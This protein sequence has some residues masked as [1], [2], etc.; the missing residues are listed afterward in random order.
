[1]KRH[2]VACLL[3][4]LAAVGVGCETVPVTGRSHLVLLSGGEETKLG[5]EAY[6]QILAKSKLSTDP[7]ANALVQRVGSRIAAVTGQSYPWEYRVIEDRQARP[8][9]FLST[10]PSEETR[11][12]Q[13]DAWLPE[14]IQRY[15]PSR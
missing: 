15:R 1:M 8:P 3:V 5:T 12:R 4:L 2:P 9:E 13:I 14:A 11:I 6:Q 7:A 10:H